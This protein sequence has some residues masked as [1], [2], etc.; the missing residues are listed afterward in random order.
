MVDHICEPI[1]SIRSTSD[2]LQKSLQGA[3]KRPLTDQAPAHRYK[4]AASLMRCHH[5]DHGGRRDII[6]RLSIHRR[7][8][9]AVKLVELVPRIGLG[10]AATHNVTTLRSS[11]KMDRAMRGVT[12]A[13]SARQRPLHRCLVESEEPTASPRRS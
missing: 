11:A 7:A 12:P 3:V 1:S 10:E 2:D 9:E 5:I 6:A 4:I 8:G 13:L